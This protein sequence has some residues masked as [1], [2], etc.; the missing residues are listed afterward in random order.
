MLHQVLILCCSYLQ[1]F[2]A[3]PQVVVEQVHYFLEDLLVYQMDSAKTHHLHR[4]LSIE[5]VDLLLQ[6]RSKNGLNDRR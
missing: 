5:L 2:L 1:T 4:K 6:A 3:M